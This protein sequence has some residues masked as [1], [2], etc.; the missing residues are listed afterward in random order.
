MVHPAGII[1][2]MGSANERRQ[3]I[4]APT[5]IGWA[6]N[7]NNPWPCMF[8]ITLITGPCHLY[9]SV[10]ANYMKFPSEAAPD[11]MIFR[12]PWQLLML[13]CLWHQTVCSCHGDGRIISKLG[14]WKCKHFNFGQFFL[15]SMN[16]YYIDG[17]ANQF[18]IS[19]FHGNHGVR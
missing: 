9:F 12:S 2:V 13:W 14:Q 4:V 5:L 7:Q 1:P 8:Y 19:C 16:G 15:S 17:Y 18:I 11:Q 10:V 6:H 3:Y